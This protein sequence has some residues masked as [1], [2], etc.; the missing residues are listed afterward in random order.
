VLKGVIMSIRKKVRHLSVNAPFVLLILLLNAIFGL[1]ADPGRNGRIAF[2][3]NPTGTNQ[4]YTINP[5]GTDLFQVTNLPL[6]SDNGFALYGD[7]S[8]DGQRIVFP[9]D[10]S[11]A[12]ELYVINADGTGLMQ[13]THDGHGGAVPRWSPD[14]MHIVFTRG[15]DLS[16]DFPGVG[17]AVITTIRADGTEEKLLTSRV[18]QS[19]GAEYTVDGKHIVFSS[20]ID[21]LVAALWIMDTDGKHQ[22]RLTAP[23]LEPGAPD[24]S[25]DGKQVVFYNHQNTPKPTSIFKMNLDGSRVTRLTSP[26]H[27]DT[28]PVYSPDGTK[29]LFMSDRLSPGSFDTFV[30][31]ADGSQKKRIIEGAFFPNWGTQP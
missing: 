1:A 19:L 11:G 28:L 8:P 5:D 24:V 30:M 12:L 25:P 9:H 21:G 4:I 7:F 27:M 29:I 13:I 22:R 16:P 3:A 23:E 6:A 14:G 31:N 10:M 17:G 20:Q 18:W 26:G 15:V 2:V